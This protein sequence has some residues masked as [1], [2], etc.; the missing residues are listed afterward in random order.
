MVDHVA[1]YSVAVCS[2]SALATDRA[3]VTD[4]ALKVNEYVS[5]ENFQIRIRRWEKDV[6]P[7]VGID[8]Q[9]VVNEQIIDT[10]DVG[11]VLL[12]DKLGHPTA[13]A[14]SGTAEEARRFLSRRSAGENVSLLVFFRKGEAELSEVYLDE[15]KRVILFREELRAAGVFWGEYSST[16]ELAEIVKIHLPRSVR[17]L[18]GNG[19]NNADQEKTIPQNAP[20]QILVPEGALEVETGIIDIEIDLAESMEDFTK[21][22][23]K[24][25]SG[26]DVLVEKFTPV[27]AELSQAKSAAV[28]DPKRIKIAIRDAS[29]ILN[30][31]SAVIEDELPRMTSSSRRFIDSSLAMIGLAGAE[32]SAS[33]TELADLKTGIEALKGSALNALKMIIEQIDTVSGFPR[34]T[35]DMNIAK[36][37]YVDCN[38]Q[39]RLITANF[40]TSLDRIIDELGR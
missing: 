36:S 15:L 14:E 20:S 6:T 24:I 16:E 30:D 34:L 4:A 26:T 17:A 38:E 21:A 11:I 39:L 1:I 13:R 31:Q 7:G 3:A 10:A 19:D 40:V 2:P 37:R 12:G 29:Q 23:R 28:R 25:G 32:W 22:L 27:T 5:H 35:R 33:T 18:H 9:S 8:A